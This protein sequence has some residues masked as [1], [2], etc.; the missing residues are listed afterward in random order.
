MPSR[1]SLGTVQF[2]LDYGIAN[3]NGKV[4]RQKIFEILKSAHDGGINCLDTAYDYGDSE[5]VIGAYLKEHANQFQVVSKLPAL[6]AYTDGK[7]EEFL[8]LTLQRIGIAKLYGYLVH[9]F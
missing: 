3:K 9:K 4:S 2:G 5:D 8:R 1:I 7:A 6:T